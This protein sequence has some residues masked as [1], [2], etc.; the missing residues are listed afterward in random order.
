MRVTLYRS[1]TMGGMPLEFGRNRTDSLPTININTGSSSNNIGHQ[2][3][4]TATG[5]GSLFLVALATKG[6]SSSKSSQEPQT[7]QPQEQ[8][9]EQ[10]IQ[11]K[12][13][14]ATLLEN[15]ISAADATIKELIEKTDENYIKNLETNV[16]DLEGELFGDN[17]KYKD[18]AKKIQ[19]AD[20]NIT[21]TSKD[22]ENATNDY[23]QS[24]NELNNLNRQKDN[25]EALDN[26]PQ[27]KARVTELDALIESKKIEVN[28]KKTKMDEA[29]TQA[30]RAKQERDNL[31]EEN[32]EQF[33]I[34][35]S[36]LQEYNAAK[37]KFTEAK[38]AL[39]QNKATINSLTS[40][41]AELEAQLRLLNTEIKNARNT[42]IDQKG[43]QKLEDNKNSKN[44]TAG[45][46]DNGNWWKRNMPTWLGGSNKTNKAKYKEANDNKNDVIAN[47]MKKHNCSRHQAIK[48]LKEIAAKEATKKKPTN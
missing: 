11:G 18:L 23:N 13:R 28:N 25:A 7:Q 33:T 16:K 15:Q 43:S 9:P 21:R 4:Q 5:L 39:E 47:Y 30:E 42:L 38:G 32:N 48:E 44:Y 1:Y 19:T 6:L 22:L 37:Q 2:L 31:K 27:A 12:E 29:N 8:T 34:V 35:Q 24:N 20:A 14:E 17:A 45:V 40:Q 10:I 36:K 3:G 46:K 41:K 26:D